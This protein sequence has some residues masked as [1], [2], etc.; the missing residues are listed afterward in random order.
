MNLFLSRGGINLLD[1]NT[2]KFFH[3]N[4]KGSNPKRFTEHEN[5]K[6]CNAP[7]ELND[8]VINNKKDMNY[9]KCLHN[10]N[11]QVPL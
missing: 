5:L 4:R 1:E 9:Q 6:C 11:V 7:K 10:C 2:G 8:A 3:L